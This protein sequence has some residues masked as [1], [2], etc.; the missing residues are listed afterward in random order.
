M[1]RINQETIDKIIEEYIKRGY[2]TG[3][4][5]ASEYYEIPIDND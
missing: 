4:Q 5:V 1:H 2:T 3:K